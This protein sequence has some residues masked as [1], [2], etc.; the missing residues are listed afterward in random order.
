LKE[1]WLAR[2]MVRGVAVSEVV[3]SDAGVDGDGAVTGVHAATRARTMRSSSILIR[4]AF[5]SLKLKE[6]LYPSRV[7]H[8]SRIKSLKRCGYGSLRWHY[9]D[10]VNGV[11]SKTVALSAWLH[12]APPIQL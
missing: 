7:L 2:V 11:G 9:P 10:Q 5:P 8:L 3:V 4:M 6:R 1:P 12:Q